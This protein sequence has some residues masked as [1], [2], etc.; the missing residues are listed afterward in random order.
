MEPESKLNGIVSEPLEEY[1]EDVGG[2][3]LLLA[4]RAKKPRGTYVVI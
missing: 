2:R 3:D 4:K 1:W